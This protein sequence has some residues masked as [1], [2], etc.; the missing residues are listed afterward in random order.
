MTE[1]QI[2]ATHGRPRAQHGH[3]HTQAPNVM[4]VAMETCR[5]LLDIN[6]PPRGN[7]ART[8]QR[9]SPIC[10]CTEALCT[11]A[12]THE[13]TPATA[14]QHR[15]NVRWQC[16]RLTNELLVPDVQSHVPQSRGHSTNHPVIVYPQQLHQDREALLFPHRRP[17]VDRPL[18]RAE[19]AA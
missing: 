9:N 5:D 16:S 6:L 12:D 1:E 4:H 3:A 11:P 13:Q 15:N 19:G 7:Q 10:S 17:D 14:T 18:D 2:T 8:N